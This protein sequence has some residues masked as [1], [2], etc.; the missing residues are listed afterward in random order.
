MTQ[1]AQSNAILDVLEALVAEKA[2]PGEFSR[3]LFLLELASVEEENT[4]LAFLM[5]ACAIPTFFD[6]NVIGVLRNDSEETEQNQQLLSAL[7][8]FH[9]VLARE[10]GGFVYHD[11]V[12]ESVL[13]DWTKPENTAVFHQIQ[14]R[15]V[16]YYFTAA[17]HAFQLGDLSIALREI[18]RAI[19][20]DPKNID[21]LIMRATTLFQLGEYDSALTDL[22]R[23]VQIYPYSS[24]IYFIRGRV[25]FENKSFERSIANYALAIEMEPNQSDFYRW[26][27]LAYLASKD[28][29]GALNDLNIGIS[30]SPNAADLYF[31]RGSILHE[32]GNY[33]AAIEDIH[34]A[35]ELKPNQVDHYLF[36]RRV[37]RD[38]GDKQ[39][40]LSAI[41]ATSR[42]ITLLPEEGFLYYLRGRIYFDL[43]QYDEALS[44][45]NLALR[46]DYRDVQ[47][48]FQRSQL[49]M[50][51]GEI[52]A[53]IED[54]TWLIANEP[55]QPSWFY[56]RA[57]AYLNLNRNE[58]ALNDIQTCLKY[59]QSDTRKFDVRI[60]VEAYLILRRAY[61]NLQDNEAAILAN[62]KA[63]ELRPDDGDLRYQR[64][65]IY[66]EVGDYAA[67]LYDWQKALE[68]EFTDSSLY[69][70]RSHLYYELGLYQKA[71][72]DAQRI[73]NG[74]DGQVKS[75]YLRLQ[76]DEIIAWRRKINLKI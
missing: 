2:S 46:F 70:D 19:E 40:Y 53:A 62:T 32:N 39:S 24:T 29:D 52:S 21:A 36:L 76:N 9:F 17:Q 14:S 5:R 30:L 16:D 66:R 27:S 57:S 69:Y 54:L 26:R 56:Q 22:T 55:D 50:K 63:I 37:Y 49:L 65:R 18:S 67:C 38:K 12:R 7:Q 71:L 45:F 48:L 6:E 10:D 51:N 59:L 75:N 44:D 25:Y 41:D 13:E 4:I 31:L 68:L 28:V 8:E 35:V 33:D 60:A 43:Q 15:L 1:N 64:G 42:A 34:R 47:L 73:V 11:N 61:R 58:E 3:Q 20:V 72:Y 23:V 74:K